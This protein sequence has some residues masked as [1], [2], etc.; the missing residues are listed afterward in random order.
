MKYQ[1]EGTM[2]NNHL[3][4]QHMKYQLEETIYNN[5]LCDQYMKYQLEVQ[6]TITICVIS[7]WNTN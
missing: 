6:C 2:Y 4:D 7:T 1:L 5:H 3:S